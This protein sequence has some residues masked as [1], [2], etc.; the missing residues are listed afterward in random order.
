[1]ALH[2]RFLVRPDVGVFAPVSF[3][4][5][6][7]SRI[8]MPGL[9]PRWSHTLV[10]VRIGEGGAYAE[11]TV[12]SEPPAARPVDTA[13]RVIDHTPPAHVRVVD[14]DGVVLHEGQHSA[15]FRHDQP[16]QIGGK[17]YTVVGLDWPGR[18]IRSGVC[19]G[20]I[21]WQ[22]VRVAEADQPARLPARAS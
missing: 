4:E 17:R 5:L 10:D 6:L 3:A 11:L 18:D 1:V 21:D 19:S 20:D 2:A 16:L 8:T 12:M 13:L 7:Q 14:V 9:D 15:P 22:E